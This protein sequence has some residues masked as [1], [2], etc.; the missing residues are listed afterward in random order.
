VPPIVEQAVKL[1]AA[2]GKPCVLWM[3]LGIVNEQA[4]EAAKKAGLLV[5]MDKCMMIEHKRF[6]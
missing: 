2:Y 6:F 5:V 3:Q 4:A 1:K